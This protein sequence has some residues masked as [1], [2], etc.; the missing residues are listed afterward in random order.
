[1]CFNDYVFYCLN[2]EELTRL[3]NQFQ[4][5]NFHE[6]NVV[7]V[8]EIEDSLEGYSFYVKTETAFWPDHQKMMKFVS[9]YSKDVFVYYCVECPEK[10]FYECNDLENGIFFL[11]DENGDLYPGAKVYKPGYEPDCS[12]KRQ[13]SACSED[14]IRCQV[15]D[16]V[17]KGLV[18]PEEWYTKKKG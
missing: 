1:M 16:I 13:D 8:E 11:R 3:Y 2:L 4:D 17:D 14:D 10:D 9:E 7:C 5:K 15:L 12:M 6:F 18:P